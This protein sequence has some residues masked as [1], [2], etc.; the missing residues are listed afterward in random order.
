MEK[1]S[2][3]IKHIFN[4]CHDGGFVSK[5]TI[6]QLISVMLTKL[7]QRSRIHGV[8]NKPT[9]AAAAASAPPTR[10][11]INQAEFQFSST[12]GIIKKKKGKGHGKRSRQ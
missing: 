1:G 7:N 10:F 9:A 6:C 8:N 12:R 2:I 11:H 5:A 4:A 3:L